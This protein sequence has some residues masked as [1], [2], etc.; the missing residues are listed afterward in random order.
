[1]VRS[2]HLALAAAVS[3]PI[4]FFGSRALPA[5][6]PARSE[7]VSPKVCAACHSQIAESYAKTGMGRSF[8]R[9]SPQTTL[10]DF[11]HGDFY[12][13]RSDTHF[14]MI[15][16]DGAWYQRRWQ[17]GF[18]GR[19]MNVE[20]MRVDYILGSGKHARSYLHRTARGTLI[21]LPLGWY[22]EN[23]G[24]WGMVPGSD[25]D[26]PRSRRFVSYKCM[27]CHN[28]IPQIPAANQAP[29][30]DPVFTGELPEGIDCQRCHGPGGEHVRR[31][32][33]PG[34]KPEDIR[35]A[36]VNPARLNSKLRMDVCQQCHLETTSQR[37]PATLV[38]FDRGPF[39]FIPGQ[40]LE[41]FALSFDHAPGMGHDDKFEIVGA[42]AYRLRQSQCFLK[43][44]GKL[45]CETCHNPHNIPRGAEAVAHYASVCRQCHAAKQG[46][47][48]PIDSLIAAGKHTSAP[49][50]AGCH[51]PKR[52]PTDTPNLVMTDHLIQR[53]PPG[54]LLAPFR[55][56]IPKEYQG[57]VVPYYPSPLPPTSENAL[58]LA[59]AQVGLK[60]NLAAGLPQL[61]REIARQKPANAQ[62]YIVLGDALQS[63]GKPREAITAYEQALR[64]KPNSPRTLGSLSD[65]LA[66]AGEHAR[67]EETLK[68]AVQL[69]PSDPEAW[70]KYGL[71]DSD[72]SKIEK[73]IALDPTLPEKSRKLGEILLKK[74]DVNGAETA[75][76]DALRIDPWDEDAWDL[77]GR[78]HSEKNEPAEAMFDFARAV[79]L[80][81]GSPVYLYDF[82]L[83]LARA[84]RFDEAEQRIRAALEANEKSG[85][86]HE[87][88][89]RLLERKRQW[90]QSARE[91]RRALEL[92]P[93]LERLRARLA[94]VLQQSGAA[95]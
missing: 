4:A 75:L 37:I 30:S 7:Y 65:A 9:P 72:P 2:R 67:A 29:D 33:A 19:E 47:I 18:D 61:Q 57:A 48:P 92:R 91:Y 40:A 36:I 15:Q 8:A 17:T 42:S 93:D 16:R 1:M 68:R 49:D 73:A 45:T 66:A 81:P 70:Y 86:A 89:G 26:H 59:V 10:E 23:G 32:S 50:C 34:S 80:R 62:F 53:R 64:L 85:E 83:A 88:L 24:H 52:R 87:L 6:A 39:S 12:H 94:S 79:R 77:A 25:L 95:Q 74:G 22:S 84:S 5:A 38:R 58:Y 31:A 56:Q 71:L 43:S 90:A 3:I 44:A 11:T 76:K 69:A 54:N 51:M 60:N 28:G 82:A 55:E 46:A 13:D 20:E 27:S 41:S 14:S 21:E 63:A 35:A 78:L